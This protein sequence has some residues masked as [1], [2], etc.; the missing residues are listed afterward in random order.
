MPIYT[1]VRN[2]RLGDAT[3]HRLVIVEHYTPR[4]A[5]LLGLLDELHIAEL[6]MPN[7]CVGTS[8]LHAEGHCSRIGIQAGYLSKRE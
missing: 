5:E 6:F 7:Y 3:N 2:D 4:C 1:P 8:A